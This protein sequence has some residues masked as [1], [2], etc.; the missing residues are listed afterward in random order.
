MANPPTTQD[1]VDLTRLELGEDDSVNGTIL[2]TEIVLL[3]NAGARRLAAFG[4]FI[5]TC[6]EMNLEAGKDLYLMPPDF[7][8]VD[9]VILSIP[10]GAQW[11]IQP[12][13]LPQLDPSHATGD[14]T[15]YLMWGA[16]DVATGKHRYAMKLQ[17]VPNQTLSNVVEVFFRQFTAE[18]NLTGTNPELL[19]PWADG[20]VSYALWKIYRRLGRRYATERAEARE[21]WVALLQQAKKAANPLTFD[22][23]PQRL[24]TMGTTAWDDD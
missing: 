11:P 7:Y 15:N 17:P 4:H 24:D 8:G 18:F 22:V 10:G 1:L 13:T 9:S 23:P 21:E 16:N 20:T 3:L 14:P 2:D 6:G 19:Q 5:P 12:M